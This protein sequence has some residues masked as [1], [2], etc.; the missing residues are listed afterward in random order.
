VI[1]F[2]LQLG[3]RSEPCNLLDFLA[4]EQAMAADMAALGVL[5]PF[6]VSS[7]FSLEYIRLVFR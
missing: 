6:K 3:F 4:E 2:L 7:C 1:G 5:C